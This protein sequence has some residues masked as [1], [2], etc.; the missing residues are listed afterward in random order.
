MPFIVISNDSKA[1]ENQFFV[2]ASEVAQ[3]AFD[4]ERYFA[5]A[6][7]FLLA[8]VATDVGNKVVEVSSAVKVRL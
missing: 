7:S 5:N 2:A 4:N 6:Q 1:S 8:P 3:Q